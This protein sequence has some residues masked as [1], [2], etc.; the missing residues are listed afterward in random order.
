M[1]VTDNVGT[2]ATC[3]VILVNPAAPV[4]SN[5]AVVQPT[6]AIPSGVIDISATSASQLFYSV[7]GGTM[8]LPGATFTNLPAGVYD[9]RVRNMA[10]GC[11]GISTANPI[12][13]VAPAGCCQTEAGTLER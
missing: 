3:G 2:S 4:V 12:T 13:L 8:F 10:T 7:D 5:V 6:C 11:V 1:T 9:V